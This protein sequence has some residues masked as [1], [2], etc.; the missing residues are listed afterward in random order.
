MTTFTPQQR[1]VQVAL[2]LQHAG[3]PMA[4]AYMARQ[5]ELEL[6]KV[7]SDARLSSFEGIATSLATLDTLE[8]L[9]AEHKAAWQG[10]MVEATRQYAVVLADMPEEER[11]E[12]SRSWM[13]S[14]NREMDAQH[15]SLAARADWID[16][17]RTVCRLA[18]RGREIAPT[19]DGPVYA[20]DDDI[21]ELYRQYDRINAASEVEH[22]L[23]NERVARIKAG[24]GKIGS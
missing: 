9:V 19:A 2:Q 8:Q 22:Q 18:L 7:L 12:T 11:T 1:L 17:A 24:L 14:L 10:L 20:D 3:I 21:A 5:A 4:Q 23:M 6:D 15:R 13:A 16:A